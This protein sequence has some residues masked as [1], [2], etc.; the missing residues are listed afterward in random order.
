M[1][2][3][4]V[5]EFAQDRIRERNKAESSKILLPGDPLHNFIS[6]PGALTC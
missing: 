2:Q 4:L 3:T 1:L 5:P 6:A